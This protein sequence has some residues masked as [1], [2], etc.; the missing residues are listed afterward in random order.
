MLS[1]VTHLAQNRNSQF[2]EMWA[3]LWEIK[4]YGLLSLTERRLPIILILEPEIVCLHDSTQLVRYHF[5]N[6]W[7]GTNGIVSLLQHVENEEVK[8]VYI[9]IVQLPQLGDNLWL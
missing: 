4:V 3:Q 7:A 5:F 8:I 9:I 2:L 1:G 6:V